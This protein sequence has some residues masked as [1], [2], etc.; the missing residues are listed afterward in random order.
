MPTDQKR[1][2]S[3]KKPLNPKKRAIQTARKRESRGRIYLA[4]IV[5]II[6]AVGVGWYFY[7]LVQSSS[8]GP[9]FAIAAPSVVTIHPGHQVTSTV[10]VT[11]VNNFCRTC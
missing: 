2:N 1:P 8:R 3:Q 7:S 4:I 10:N 9:N 11:S 5:I 6:V